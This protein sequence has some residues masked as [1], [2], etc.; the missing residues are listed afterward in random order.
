[1]PETTTLQCFRITA[2]AHARSVA[3]VLAVFQDANLVSQF[4]MVRRQSGL[5][6]LTANFDGLDDATALGLAGRILRLPRVR[7]AT[8]ETLHPNAQDP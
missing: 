8:L 7:S 5:L 2:E 1:M 4:L 6:S 3:D